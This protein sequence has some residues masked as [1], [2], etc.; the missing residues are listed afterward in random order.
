MHTCSVLLFAFSIVKIL[1]CLSTILQ[2]CLMKVLCAGKV[3]NV[4]GNVNIFVKN[5][6]TQFEN[7]CSFNDAGIPR[8]C[9][10][11]WI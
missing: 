3:I 10:I 1:T 4:A 8:I 11:L 9:F 5:L 7:S 2:V 6:R